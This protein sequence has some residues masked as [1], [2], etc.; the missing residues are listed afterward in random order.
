MAKKLEGIQVAILVADGFEQV[1]LTGPKKALEEAGA[2]TFIVSPAKGQV[3]SWDNANWGED[4]P[5]DIDLEKAN[6]D[7]FDALLLP[8]GRINPDKLRV[9]EKAVSFTK[10]FF[11]RGK[12]VGAICHAPWTVIET[13][14]VA[15][16]KVTSYPSLKTDL[17]NAGAEWVDEEVVVDGGLVTSRKPDDIPA[18]NK[19][20]I[21]E[22]ALIL[23][24]K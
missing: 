16:R 7:K 4:F 2:K 22:I 18:F 8:G 14:A 1:E 21:E 3:K 10:A 9:V 17:I 15:G 24:E 11:D 13:G 20:L 5:V 12:P 6:P 23:H 19:K